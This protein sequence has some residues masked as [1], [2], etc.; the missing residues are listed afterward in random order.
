MHTRLMHVLGVSPT[1]KAKGAIPSNRLAAGTAA[2]ASPE[3]SIPELPVMRR[4]EAIPHCSPVRCLFNA[5]M[6]WIAAGLTWQQ[7]LVQIRSWLIVDPVAARTW[8]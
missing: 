2:A 3:R 7:L 4:D 8:S 1:A 6:G 5:I